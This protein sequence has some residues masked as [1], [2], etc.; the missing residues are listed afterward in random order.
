MF[1]EIIDF[2]WGNFSRFNEKKLKNYFYHKFFY[3]K[4]P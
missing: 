1:I 2:F 4:S 3:K